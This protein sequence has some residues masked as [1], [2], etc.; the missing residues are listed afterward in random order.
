MSLQAG[1]KSENL[2]IQSIDGKTEFQLPSIIEC[3]DIPSD[4]D[5]I[6]SPSVAAFFSHLSDIAQ[7]IPEV[8]K[9]AKILLLLCHDLTNI[10]HVIDQRIGPNDDSPFVVAPWLGHNRRGLYR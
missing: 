4:R 2:L 8:D 9:D 1:R 6:P 3:S 5:E 7:N 10:H